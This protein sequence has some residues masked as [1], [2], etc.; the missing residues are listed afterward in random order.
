MSQ[1]EESEKKGKVG[2]SKK[3]ISR[4]RITKMRAVLTIGNERE[5]NTILYC[6]DRKGTGGKRRRRRLSAL[7]WLLVGL[8]CR[9]R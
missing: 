1:P 6:P 5:A 4:K 2:L 9:G 3:V 8:Y 7:G